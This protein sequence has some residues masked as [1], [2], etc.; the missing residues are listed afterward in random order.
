MDVKGTGIMPISI[1]VREN[2]PDRFDGW[3]DSLSPEARRI[4][5]TALS[6]NWYPVKIAMIEA[7]R[8]V[9]D[10]FFDGKEEG[11]WEMGRFS[12]DYSLK[13]VYR[14]F[15][16]L[17]SPGFIISRGS[18]IFSNYYRPAEL[19]VVDKG[20]NHATLHITHFPEPHT[21]IEFRLGGWVE[22][23]LE[24]S[25]CKSIRVDITKSLTRGDSVTELKAKWV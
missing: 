7:T 22:R 19:T 11:A 17:G 20:P 23:A 12:A 10:T 24:L 13:G 18:K 16:K 2:F 25:G 4:M 5:E 21:L 1:F 3:L 6:S 14:Y 9:I 15:V 8:A